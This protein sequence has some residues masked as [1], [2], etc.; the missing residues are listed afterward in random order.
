MASQALVSLEIRA[1]GI[2][3]S[4]WAW[5]KTNASPKDR[6]FLIETEIDKRIG[7]AVFAEGRRTIRTGNPRAEL[8]S[9]G[10]S[11]VLTVYTGASML[12]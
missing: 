8:G 7:S 5:P 11:R 6:P 4:A 3:S 2:V 9:I 1:K 12:P 10:G